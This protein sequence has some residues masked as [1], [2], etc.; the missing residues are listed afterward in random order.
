VLLRIAEADFAKS[1][2]LHCL[3]R[4]RLGKDVDCQVAAPAVVVAAIGDIEIAVPM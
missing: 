1:A 4:V 3:S 2:G